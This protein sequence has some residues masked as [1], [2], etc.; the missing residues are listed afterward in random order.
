MKQ[1]YQL[2]RKLYLIVKELLAWCLTLVVLVP[3]TIVVLNAFKTDY[4]ALNMSLSLP[5]SFEWENFVTVWEIGNIPRSYMNS[6]ILSVS[7]VTL[8]VFFSTICAFVLA[9]NKTRINHWIYIYFSLGLMFPVN[10]VTVV[11]VMRIFGLYNTRLGVII[12]FTALIIPLSV[13][14]YYGFINS[15]P[16]ELDEAAI[17]DGAG[18]YRIFFSI[19]FPMLKPVTVTVIMINFLSTWN[20][21]TIPLYLLPDPDKAVI[22]Q[23]VYN[24]FGTFT[25]QWNLVSVTIIYAILPIL[26]VYII[27][28]KYIISG[29]VAGA[30]KG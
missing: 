30:V 18:G 24:F 20:D 27:G 29:M 5:S 23:Q 22:V 4:A 7:S 9:R 21:F 2:A 11:K 26:I 12:L 13:F 3:F 14:L 25:A 8:S 6:L 1:H 28:Q 15:I 10:M 17:M 16:T 19:I